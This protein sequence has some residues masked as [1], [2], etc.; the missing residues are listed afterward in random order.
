ME[1]NAHEL[2]LRATLRDS[3]LEGVVRL[4]TTE[5]FACSFLVGALVPLR[6][7]Y[8]GLRLELVLSNTPTD[9]LRRDADV[10]IRFVPEGQR[11]TPDVLVARKLGDEPFRLYGAHAYLG[12]RGAPADPGV[13]AGHDVVVYAGPHPAAAWCASAFRGAT[14]ALSAP[15][16]TVTAA[17]IGAGLGLGVVPVRMVRQVPQ[18][19]PLSPVVAR[20]SG[21]LVMHP[22]LQ[23]VP[24][25]RAVVD[26]LARLFR[27]EER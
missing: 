5:A 24:R 12:R 1:E 22:D 14:V 7:S 27:S 15:S 3:V 26:T 18:L 17:G 10:A 2:A 11:P 13:L 25:I 16:M 23:Q 6:E 9:L 8:P 21:W 20:G 4:A 19:V